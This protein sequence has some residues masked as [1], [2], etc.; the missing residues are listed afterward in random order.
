M[1]AVGEAAL[2]KV[3]YS[4]VRAIDAD[5]DDLNASEAETEE[6]LKVRFPRVCRGPQGMAC[7][8]RSVRELGRSHGFLEK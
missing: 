6:S 2:P 8:E 7:M 5:G 4:L 1:Q 3:W